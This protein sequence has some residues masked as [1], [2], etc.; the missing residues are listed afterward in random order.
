VVSHCGFKVHLLI[1]VISLDKNVGACIHGIC[2]VV[3]NDERPL[4]F[5]GGQKGM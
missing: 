5:F 1:G 3:V 4:W 2:R